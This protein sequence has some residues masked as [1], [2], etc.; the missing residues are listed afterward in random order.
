M[1]G[2]NVGRYDEIAVVEEIQGFVA[3]VCATPEGHRSGQR[4]VQPQDR[5]AQVMGSRVDEVEPRTVFRG[6]ADARW[7]PAPKIDRPDYERHRR[8]RG[9]DRLGHERQLFD[10]FVK[11]SRPHLETVPGNDWEALAIAQHFGLATRLL[12]WTANPLAA[13]FFAVEDGSESVDSAVW[14]YS[15][16][17]DLAVG[18][19]D[20]FSIDEVGLFYP[21]HIAARIVVQSACFTAH[22]QM[23]AD[24][25]QSLALIRI[26]G[27]CR[28]HIRRQLAGLGVSRAALFPDLEGL[29]SNANW[30]LKSRG[31]PAGQQQYEAGGAAHCR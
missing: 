21:P 9:I 25:P 30:L 31:L 4:I 17:G 27:R 1:T 10:H 11:T 24:W 16:G 19:S 13:L 14:F 20:P 29:A 22:P 28:E 2:A 8:W 23:H 6:Q 15:H 3:L 5:V 12:D 7:V 26:P 18:P